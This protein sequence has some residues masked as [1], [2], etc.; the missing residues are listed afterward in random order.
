MEELDLTDNTLLIFTYDHGGRHL[1]R[2]APLFH[3]FGTLWEGGIRVTL[4][5]QWPSQLSGGQV[6]ERPTIAMDLTATIL[7]AAGR[8]REELEL[9]G[10]S[11]L[12]VLRNEREVPSPPLFW[13]ITSQMNKMWAVRHENWK[14]VVDRGTQL[15]FDLEADIGE[16][17]NLF[18]ARP[19]VARELRATLSEWEQSLPARQ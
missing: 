13:R 2:S 14:Y 4:L 17:N 1:V 18:A 10:S 3:G 5:V 9:D 19:E 7:A 11:L 15:L 16:R 6:V 8:D 12:P